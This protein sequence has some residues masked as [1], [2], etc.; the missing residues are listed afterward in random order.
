MSDRI[1]S[2][3][4]GDRIP[5]DLKVGLDMPKVKCTPIPGPTNKFWDTFGDEKQPGN[6]D[7]TASNTY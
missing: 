2:D 7:H 1:S 5:A 4:E 3:L 6:L